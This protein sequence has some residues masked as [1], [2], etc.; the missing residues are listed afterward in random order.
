MS[1]EQKKADLSNPLQFAREVVAERAN[2]DGFTHYAMDVLAGE[3]DTEAEM[4]GAIAV[5]SKAS[6]E[7]TRLRSL[8]AELVEALNTFVLIAKADGWNDG[9]HPMRDAC[10][11]HGK[12]ALAR[13]TGGQ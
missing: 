11:Y 10:L 2:E 7:L 13:A 4:S 5:A 12:L 8:N 6:A 1:A 3:N 9:S